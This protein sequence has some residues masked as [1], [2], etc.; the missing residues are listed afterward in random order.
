MVALGQCP[1]FKPMNAEKFVII[2][3]DDLGRST[4][5]TRA[6]IEAHDRGIVTAASMMAGGDAFQEA[7]REVLERSKLSLGL[8]VTLCDG[9]AIL[10][11][12][13]IPDLVDPHGFFIKSP[14]MTWLSFGK[15]R[16]IS[17]VE[18]EVKAQFDLL[19]AAGV[20]PCYIDSHHH[21]HMHPCVFEVLCRLASEKGVEWIRIPHEPA[22]VAF[23]LRSR[24]RGAM[25]FIEWAVFRV[26]CT[27]NMRTAEQYGLHCAAKVYGLSRTGNIDEQ[28]LLA[29]LNDIDDQTKDNY[30]NEIF[31]HPDLASATGI[32]EL[33]ALTSVAV[34]DRLQ[35]LGI[36]CIGYKEISLDEKIFCAAK[37]IL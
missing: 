12:A 32:R 4:S 1:V 3:A 16:V 36:R 14:A 30:I 20:H 11:H 5:T 26:L 23:R 22:H 9:R 35:S 33:Q 37:E 29:V 25:P 19:E 28:Y 17:Q 21:L 7:A 24:L 18:M 13:S 8:H 27:N 2:A 6:I 34:S 31:T 15:A 10:P